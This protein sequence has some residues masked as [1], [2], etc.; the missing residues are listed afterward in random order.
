VRVNVDGVWLHCDA[1]FSSGVP[2]PL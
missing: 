1:L 2:Q